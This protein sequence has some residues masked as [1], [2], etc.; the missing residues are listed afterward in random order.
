MF[1]TEALAH[2]FR[3]A[4]I[5]FFL[6]W[7]VYLYGLRKNS[8]MMKVMFITTVCLFLGFTKDSLFF[9]DA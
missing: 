8:R 1:F 9:F 4:A 7:S 6:L 3:G 2:Q 5:M